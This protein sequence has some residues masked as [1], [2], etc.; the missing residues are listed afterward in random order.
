MVIFL[1]AI[2]V[3]AVVGYLAVLY[4]QRSYS[5]RLGQEK[6]NVEKIAKHS[7]DSKLAEISQLNLSG[8]SLSE[9]ETLDKG[10]HYLKNRELPE[11]SERI[12]DLEDAL[13]H[14]QFFRL[15]R[16]LK[17][18][19]NK[20]AG[21]QQHY[22][23]LQS[24]LSGIE[25]STRQHE[26]ELKRLQYKY[27]GLRSTLLSKNF[28]FGPSIDQ[29]EEK[30]ADIEAD[31]ANYTKL[32]ESGDY[33]SSEEPL[34]QLKADMNDLED[35]VSQVPPLFKNLNNVFPEQ[36]AELK[37]GLQQMKESNCLF[38]E[39]LGAKVE[40]LNSQVQENE[41]NLKRLKLDAAQELDAQI[42]QEIDQIYAAIELEYTAAQQLS[43]KLAVFGK[44]LQHAQTQQKELA[45]E[46]DRLGQN[47]T[48]NEQEE[49]RSAA[50][51]QT[52]KKIQDNFEHIDHAIEQSTGLVYSKA[53]AQVEQDEQT[54]T[55]TEEEQQKINQSISGLWKE[56]QDALTAVETF[57]T[58][59][60]RMK[61]EL[62]K[63]NLPGLPDNYLEYFFKVSQEIET[64]D[65][66]LNKMKIDMA[67]I[68]KTLI[69]TQSDL[70]VLDHKTTE[71]EDSS[72]LAERLLQYSNRYRNRYPEVEQA[73]QQ[74][75]SEF[76]HDYN[77]VAA[78]DT[79]S[80][81]VDT[82][83]PGAFQRI[84]EQFQS[85]KESMAI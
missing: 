14:Y 21:A 25:E 28:S 49:E 71:I 30:S 73:Y 1:I 10:Y 12:T 77:Y 29:L 52:L 41:E 16:E 44:F 51:E 17:I 85:D 2:V 34:N 50:L 65:A 45:I 18:L 43:Q 36:L 81:A 59:I 57:D 38:S 68:T 35:A 6:T 75:L 33:V 83:E 4:F 79:I 46:L 40:R 66:D 63:L 56:E 55:E 58:E 61:R 27:Q 69:N 24:K 22:N 23:E 70:D 82:V 31:F 64:L 26:G 60:H 42:I 78:L 39:D 7:L 72:K 54:L 84:S 20:T 19:Q 76:Q 67:V 32:S 80:Q 5:E 15:S 53:L 48:F 37:A 9:F 74:A 8:E 13:G 11:L 3:V 47:Y 62:E